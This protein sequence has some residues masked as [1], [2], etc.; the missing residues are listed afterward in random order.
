[1]FSTQKQLLRSFNPLDRG[2]L[3]LIEVYWYFEK[4]DIEVSIP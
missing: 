1:M 2:N 3:Y 4:R